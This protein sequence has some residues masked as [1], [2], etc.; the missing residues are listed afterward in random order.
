VQ[1]AKT[2]CPWRWPGQ[3]EDEETGLYYNRF[4]HYDT[5]AGRYI[6]QD[7]IGL[8]GGIALYAYVLDPLTWFDPK[9]LTSCKDRAKT[10]RKET[11]YEARIASNGALITVS[12]PLSLNRALS[13]LRKHIRNKDKRADIYTSERIDAER[14][15]NKASSGKKSIFDN[16]H[17]DNNGSKTDRFKHY[18]DAS[19]Q[20][21]HVW[22]GEPH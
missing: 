22:F 8:R 10:A 14:L 6:S 15:A 19:H 20:G 4:R 21:G 11:Y 7:P 3:Y 9:G 2:A 13:R 18:H 17:T 16:P 1:I 5:E 12:G